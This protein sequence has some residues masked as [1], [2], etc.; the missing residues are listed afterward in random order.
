MDRQKIKNFIHS[1]GLSCTGIAPAI[2]PI[3]TA[4]ENICPLAAGQGAERYLPK[5]LL[6]GCQSVIVVLFPY[7][8]GDE[9]THNIS[10]Y[11][12]GEDYHWVIMTY[13]EKIR[14]FLE[15]ACPDSHH[16]C[17][18]DTSPLVDRWLAYQAG[19]GYFGDNYCFINPTYGSYCFIG[20]V[21]TT[22]DLTADVPLETDCGH[23]GACR[24][25]CLGSCL[26]GDVFHYE[27]C[28]SY[29]TQKKGSLTPPEIS[30]IRKTP[31]IYGCDECQ[32][33]CPHNRDIPLTPLPEFRQSRLTWLARE[34]I[35]LLSNRQFQAAYGKRA[36]AWRGKKILLRNMAYTGQSEA[37]DQADDA[38]NKIYR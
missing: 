18:A 27:Q 9:G 21:L 5:A 32:Q 10:L 38:V 35:A 31:L 3:P 2:L 11:A 24:T 16:V 8:A 1:L 34:D 28:K 30:I 6:P 7:Y 22:I 4:K 36:F 20:S 23:C 29:L 14:D 15:T 26:D 19:L 12:Q 13:L 37:L 33:V 25:A 17:C